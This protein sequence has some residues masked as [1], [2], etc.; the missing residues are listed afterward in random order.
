MKIESPFGNFRLEKSRKKQNSS[1]ISNDFEI[2]INSA[3]SEESTLVSTAPL[4]TNA[5]FMLDTSSWQLDIEKEKVKKS[6]AEIIRALNGIR[7]KLI[8]HQL[9]VEDLKNLHKIVL[10]QDCTFI[11]PEIQDIYDQIRVR[12]EVELAKF[13]LS[14]T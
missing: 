1:A 13:N 6:G 14:R 5:L 8:N 7:L 4:Q 12:A 11:T 2:F 10:A 9:E 3:E